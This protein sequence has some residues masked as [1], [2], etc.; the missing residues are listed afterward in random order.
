MATKTRARNRRRWRHIRHAAESPQHG[1]G[2]QLDAEAKIDGQ[3]PWIRPG[4]DAGNHHA[5]SGE[6]KAQG[7]D[8]GRQA[9]ASERQHGQAKS[10]A[11][12]GC[13]NS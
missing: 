9:A 10:D 1:Q 8:Q 5:N 3:M 12:E 13:A 4:I 11:A 7:G 2:R 6:D